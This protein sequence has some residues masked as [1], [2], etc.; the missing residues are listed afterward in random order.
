MKHAIHERERT[1]KKRPP[2]RT[3]WYSSRNEWIVPFPLTPSAKSYAKFARKSSLSQFHTIRYKTWKIRAQ[4]IKAKRGTRN[5]SKRTMRVNLTQS[6]NTMKETQR[7]PKKQAVIAKHTL[8][9]EK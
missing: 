8:K 9:Y 2:E 7:R 5:A 4:P 1:E 6:K 3:H